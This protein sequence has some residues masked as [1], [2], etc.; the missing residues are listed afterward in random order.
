MD[1]LD[2]LRTDDIETLTEGACVLRG[3]AREQAPALLAAIEEV[4]LQAPLRRLVTPGGFTMSVAMSNCGERGWISD[5]HGYR[6]EENDPQTGL[7]WPAL[8]PGMRALAQTAAAAAGFAPLQPDACLI[9]RYEPG[10]RMSLH[11][12]RDEGDLSAPIVSVSLGVSAVF[13][14][15]G[16]VRSQRPQRLRL[17]HGDVVVW[18]GPARLAFHGVAPLARSHHPLTGSLRFN[19]TFRKTR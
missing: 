5:R 13:M 1:L 15:G 6:Y 7:R 19:L 2:Q 3:F 9:N 10:A 16:L 14:F 12:D 18:G 8:P 11:Q 4:T 17:V